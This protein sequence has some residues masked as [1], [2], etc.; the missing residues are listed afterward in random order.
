[1]S[2]SIVDARGRV[3]RLTVPGVTPVTVSY[4]AR[5]RIASMAQ[6]ARH[7]DAVY[8]PA[9]GFL[10]ELHDAQGHVL[11]TFRDAA[12]RVTSMTRPDGATVQIG[13]DP[14]DNLTSY[15]PPGKPAHGL[16]YNAD[17]HETS[18]L[19]PTGAA[20]AVAYDGDQAPS[21]VTR[22]DGSTITAT[23]NAAGRVATLSFGATTL[24]A[25]YD[26]AGRLASVTGPPGNGLAFTYDG[27]LPTAVTAT[28]AAPGV[29]RWTYDA[30]LRIATE[31]IGTGTTITVLRDLDGLVSDVGALSITRD[32]ATGQATD[33][34]IDG[35]Q[36]SYSHD[37]FGAMTKLTA[38]ALGTTIYAPTYTFDALGRVATKKEKS[39]TFG[40]TYDPSGRLIGTTRNGVVDAT[41]SYD[42]NG[43]RA[44]SGVVVDPE[45]RMTAGFGATYTYTANGELARVTAGTNV[46]TYTYDGRGQLVTAVL[47]AGRGTVSYGL[48][49]LGRR[50][51]RSLDGTVTNRFVY[52]SALQIAAEVSSSG[53]VTTRYV[54]GPLSHTP[55]YFIRGGQTYAILTDHLGSVRSVVRTSDGTVMQSISYD[56]WGKVLTDSSPGFQ[57]F[58]F[59]GGLYDKDTGLVHFGAREYDGTTGRWTSKDPG[60]FAGGA[61]LYAYSFGDPVN[62]VDLTGNAPCP[63][64]SHTV[65]YTFAGSTFSA[66]VAFGL[67]I[68]LVVNPQFIFDSHGHVYFGV[69][70][71]VGFGGVSFGSGTGRILQP[72]EPTE[73]ELED[74]ITGWSINGNGGF[75][76][77]AGIGGGVGVSRS[78]PSGVT[79]IE[80]SI[81][82]GSPGPSW[83]LT[84]QYTVKLF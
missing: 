55:A 45:D 77:E 72:C 48:D 21:R 2:S 81:T 80:G 83:S 49:G 82:A 3:T 79:G 1:V 24:S 78:I 75:T 57:P 17:N 41:Y 31:R 73:A 8:D 5:G 70:A 38:S 33:A 32:A 40:Y 7:L 63:P 51:T 76:T 54:Y 39:T 58:G 53:T 26:S 18:Y 46:S 25:G 59:A 52:R 67:P 19:P 16:A 50:I 84:G 13:R 12:G 65:D 10:S 15:T 22:A 60:R 36:W 6:G 64:G 28:G 29:V 62:W 47:P 37:A 69:G 68:E 27:F 66:P 61:N 20:T 23:R 43:N 35:V 71:G 14:A 9:S 30:K 34:S 44:D 11:R 4:D 42:A 56:P 74:Y